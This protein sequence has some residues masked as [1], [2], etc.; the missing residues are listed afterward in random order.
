MFYKAAISSRELQ[1]QGFSDEIT[2]AVKALERKPKEDFMSFVKRAARNEIAKDILYDEIYEALQ[3]NKRERID[4]D[5]FKTLN[6]NL[7]AYHYLESLDSK[8]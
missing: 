6:E 5:D 3:I 2:E 4:E 7:E 1:K 8:E